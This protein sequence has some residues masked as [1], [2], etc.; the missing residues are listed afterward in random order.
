MTDEKSVEIT[1]AKGQVLVTSCKQ[2]ESNPG[3]H[4]AGAGKPITDGNGGG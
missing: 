3:Y 1:A 4:F 2:S